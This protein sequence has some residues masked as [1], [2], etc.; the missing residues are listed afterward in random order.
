[1]PDSVPDEEALYLSDILVTSYHQVEDAGVKEGDIVG[2]WGAGAIG[3]L[4][5]SP[6][7]PDLSQ[8]LTSLDDM[9]ELWAASGVPSRELRT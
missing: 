5:R 3:T 8:L 7:M 9:Q 6:C 4:T 2:I 1:M